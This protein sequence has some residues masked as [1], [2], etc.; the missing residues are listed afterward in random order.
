VIALLSPGP[1]ARRSPRFG[2]RRGLGQ[3]AGAEWLRTPGVRQQCTRRGNAL[4]A[5]GEALRRVFEG[6][7]R[8]I[9]TFTEKR[10]PPWVFSGGQPKKT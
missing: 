4:A 6:V 7:F 5:V 10:P 3:L 1:A 8:A 2:G 9:W